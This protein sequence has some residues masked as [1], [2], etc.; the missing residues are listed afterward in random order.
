MTVTERTAGGLDPHGSATNDGV[1]TGWW[2]AAGTVLM[3]LTLGWGSLNVVELLAR[4]Q[5]TEVV[6]IDD[7]I[8]AVE[9]DAE[10]GSV[11]VVATGGTSTVVTTRISEGL[12]S[13]GIEQAVVGDRLVATS[14]CPMFADI[15]CSV[16][17][18]VEVPDGTD[19]D[20]RTSHGTLR[21]MG[22][23]GTVTAVTQHGEVEIEGS[24]GEVRA[25]S[26]HGDVSIALSS[27]PR[28]VRA[29]TRH[30][31]VELVIPDA[32]G[33]FRVDLRT[34][35]GDTVNAIRS[36]PAG[37]RIVELS[38]RHGDVVARYGP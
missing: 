9:I 29:D 11:R 22:E 36:D 16:S 6:Q 15:W 35:D 32:P 10:H 19:V 17:Y 20:V 37:E 4:E 30:G 38:T 12:R 3:V 33:A 18:V 25:E 27:S 2:L 31:D 1:A 5:R 21:V 26:R 8:A 23:V 28:S 24:S 7:P 34:H 13:P 14:S